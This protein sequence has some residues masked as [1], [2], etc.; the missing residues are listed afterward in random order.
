MDVLWAVLLSFHVFVFF[1]LYWRFLK[2]IAV[3]KDK[4]PVDL[5]EIDDNHADTSPN[6]Y[7]PPTLSDVSHIYFLSLA[8]NLTV[9][10]VSSLNIFSSL[11]QAKQK[12]R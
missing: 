12:P 7:C 9:T 2:D 5:M 4:S 10:K 1:A 8:V 6:G 3:R 11:Q